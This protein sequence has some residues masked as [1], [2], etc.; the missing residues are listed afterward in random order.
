MVSGDYL[1]N[2]VGIAHLI[3]TVKH[4]VTFDDY[5]E[6]HDKVLQL[7]MKIYLVN[8]DGDVI[9]DDTNSMYSMFS[10]TGTTNEG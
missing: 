2:V 8:K 5:T 4:I 6:D 7:A 1:A 3:P 10:T 9:R